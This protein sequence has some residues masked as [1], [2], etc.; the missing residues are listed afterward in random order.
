MKRYYNK[1]LDSNDN[2]RRKDYHGVI[3]MKL[4]KPDLRS[5]PIIRSR[6]HKRQGI[7]LMLPMIAILSLLSS[8]NN[9]LFF[10]V[11]S[12]NFCNNN[13]RITG[14]LRRPI[15]DYQKNNVFSIQKGTTSSTILSS[16]SSYELFIANTTDFEMMPSM[17]S[18]SSQSQKQN[19]NGW[20]NDMKI[21]Q[22]TSSSFDTGINNKINNN[23]NT[24]T[25][26]TTN[27]RKHTY[28]N[29]IAFI[30]NK[31][32]RSVNDDMIEQIQY[33]VATKIH[34]NN[35]NLLQQNHHDIFVTNS[36]NDAKNAAHQIIQNLNN[37]TLI[38]PIGGDGTVS[39]IIQ[40][41]CEEIII[42]K[43][44]NQQQSLTI[45]DAMSLLPE[46]AYIPMG[47]GNGLGS[48]VGCYLPKNNDSKRKLLHETV[49]GNNNNEPPIKTMNRFRRIIKS[50]WSKR[51]TKKQ[52][53]IASLI[54][55]ISYLNQ[56]RH[57]N[58]DQSDSSIRYNTEQQY[59]VLELPMIKVTTSNSDNAGNNNGNMNDHQ[60]DYLC[61]FAG[62]GFDS[63]LLNDFKTI[64]AWSINNRILP[65]LLS[66]VTGYCV[67][68]IVK[69]LPAA[70]LRSKHL[71]QCMVQTTSASD[72]N[73]DCWWVDHRRGDFVRPVTD[74]LNINDYNDI[75]NNED[76][77]DHER[78]TSSSSN[79]NTNNDNN[80]VLYNG[81][82]GI[83][84]CGTSSF[85]GGGLQLFPFARMTSNKMHLRI[86]NIHP[87]TGFINIPKIF[88]GTYR[89]NQLN[90]MDYIGTNFHI[91]VLPSLSASSKKTKDTVTDSSASENGYPFQHS[92]E[93]V[94]H[95]T[96]FQLNVTKSKIR[97]FCV[98]SPPSI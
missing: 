97:F 15:Y 63:L 18:D 10:V 40:L 86:A 76:D 22:D 3:R 7:S 17:M 58:D 2:S 13:R 21:N 34:N 47:T 45:D 84:A 5:S 72:N 87:L 83:L 24:L 46:F 89:N 26:L 12:W 79:T 36:E 19:I 82:V 90:V 98:T 32:A 8:Y 71:S 43:Q 29:K 50:I 77:I 70:V 91:Q 59:E 41:L 85:Y 88:Q 69:T 25:T 80:I 48:V 95:V 20:S 62:I 56:L 53:N 67:A 61:F 75:N 60:N 23:D 35:T 52:R 30:L 54:E 93:S 55:T 31:N 28:H 64:K 92:G 73:D 6:R 65:D 49:S 16:T 44:Q 14:V 78:I 1:S 42:Q 11:D 94:G 27:E 37:Y 33:T 38:V 96:Q 9:I 57:N 51:Q 39:A 74:I 4:N 66:S 68:L 81:T